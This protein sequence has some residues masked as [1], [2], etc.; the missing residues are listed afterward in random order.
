MVKNGVEMMLVETDR[1]EVLI[2]MLKKNIPR[3]GFLSA[4]SEYRGQIQALQFLGILGDYEV[5]CLNTAITTREN[6]LA[7]EE[8]R[9]NI[10][11]ENE[12]D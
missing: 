12:N 2:K 3:C 1:A 10:G 5:D 4:C 11:T 6:E 9:K 8:R 7:M